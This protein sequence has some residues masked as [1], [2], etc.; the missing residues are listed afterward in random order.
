M[1]DSKKTIEYQAKVENSL[2]LFEKNGIAEKYLD[3]EHPNQYKF[4]LTELS[5]NRLYA[6]VKS[7]KGNR[8]V[9]C[10]KLVFERVA[11]GEKNVQSLE[12]LEC[13]VA[14]LHYLAFGE[15][16]SDKDTENPPSSKNDKCDTICELCLDET[17]PA[18]DIEIKQRI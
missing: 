18:K 11:R 13:H 15:E 3:K 5:V 17:C 6:L 12:A 4:A 10:V 2:N 9:A 7:N 16:I 1:I 8:T 14:V